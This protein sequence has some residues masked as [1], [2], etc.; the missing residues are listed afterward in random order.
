M[1]NITSALSNLRKNFVLCLTY[2]D[3]SHVAIAVTETITECAFNSV[4]CKRFV[5][6][7]YFDVSY[8]HILAILLV[9]SRITGNF[10]FSFIQ[11][12]NC[13]ERVVFKIAHQS[14]KLFARFVYLIACHNK[15]FDKWFTHL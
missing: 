9:L 6:V 1:K 4:V 5:S 8:R 14:L 10:K 12:D 3:L 11:V 15:P 2:G 13:R 7:V